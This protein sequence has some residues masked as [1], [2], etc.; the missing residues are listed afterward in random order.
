LRASRL[1]SEIQDTVLAVRY[2]ALAPDAHSG[3]LITTSP[4]SG[5]DCGGKWQ[6]QWRSDPRVFLVRDVGY[7]SK[8]K[9]ISN[10]GDG[11][12]VQQL[13][14][15]IPTTFNTPCLHQNASISAQMK[16][17]YCLHYQLSLL[18]NAL[19]FQQLQR[20]TMS[21]KLHSFEDFIEELQESNSH[22][23]TGE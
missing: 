22:H 11:G 3:A 16:A 9:Q 23:L 14:K 15:S 20:S 19:A 1:S 5:G 18:V 8:H 2:H 17:A 21:L 7:L 6:R 12:A 4:H 13:T 10:A